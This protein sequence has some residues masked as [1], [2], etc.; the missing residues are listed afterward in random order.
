MAARQCRHN[1]AD[2]GPSE[3][4]TCVTS[5][6]PVAIRHGGRVCKE[7]AMMNAQRWQRLQE[8]FAQGCALPLSQQAAFAAQACTDDEP[9][10][11]ELARL[12]ALDVA[13]RSGGDAGDIAAQALAHAAAQWTG[14]TRQSLVGQ[15]LGPWQVVAHHADG[16]MGAVYR[17]ERADGSYEQAVAIK[18][19]NPAMLSAGGRQR[20]LQE[21]QILAR[22]AH[23][24]IARLLDG[25]ETADGMPYLVME[26][27]DG[28]P[29]DAWCR[30]RRSSVAERLQLMI[31]VCHAVDH[32]H[33]NLVVHRDL[34][35]G[36]I[37]VDALGEPRLLDF[38]IA[39]LVDVPGGVTASAARPLTP[40]HASPEQVSGAPITTAT[41]VYALGVL[42]YDLLTGRLPH[43]ESTDNPAALARAIVET[44]PP[45]PSRAVTSTASGTS[46]EQ[47]TQR[48]GERLT[49]QRLARELEGDLDNIVLM[50]LR[51]Q[52]ERRYASAA[53]LADD[54]ARHMAHLPVRAQ[55]DTLAYRA[56]KF[57][58]RHPVAVPSSALSL[59]AALAA[60]LLFTWRLAEERDRALVAE[61]RTAKAA[62]F[63]GS[64]LQQTGA[65]D[66]AER[67]VSVPQLLQRA[68]RKLDEDLRQEPEVAVRVRLGLGA[69][70]HSWGELDDA[71]KV[72][73]Q[74]V[75]T[76]RTMPDGEHEL[77]KGLETLSTVQHD[78]GELGAA[79]QL[80]RDADAIWR[81]IGTPWEQAQSLG[82]IAMGLNSLRRRDEAEPV[83]RD[84]IE[85]MRAVHPDGHLEIAWLLN[86]LAWGLHAM[87]RL[88]EA[89]PV[90][91][92]AV[93]MQQRL[94]A[95]RV[96][97]AQT[98]NNLAGLYYDRG[99]LGAAQRIWHEA[100]AT[101]E[102]VFGAEGHAAVA[103]GRNLLA[104][105]ALDRGRVDE[106]LRLSRQ[107]RDMLLRLQ[108]EQHRWTAAAIRGHGAALLAAGH[109]DEAEQAFA[110]AL[111]VQQAVLPAGHADQIGSH[112]NLGLVALRRG[113]AAQWRRAE[114]SLRTAWSLIE[115]IRSPDRLPVDRVLGRLAEALARQGR[116]E[117]ATAWLLRL[118]AWQRE[119]RPPGH[120][121]R[122]AWAVLQTLPPFQPR[123]SAEARDRAQV[124]LE[125]LRV[126]LG[127]QAPTVREIERALAS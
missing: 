117:E 107:A 11:H 96:E 35:P 68:A 85:R 103:R 50:A 24:H 63:V 66:D 42:L 33:R 75:S 30:A 53:A 98:L 116:H 26:F 57:V 32:A 110:R 69:A 56:R 84:A 49:Q 81:R 111:T 112:L 114:Q 113:G 55:P 21:R 12:L 94:Q 51:K 22:L 1:G 48:R 65:S 16:G 125:R 29:I 118:Q 47:A 54:L 52:P 46:R 79:L 91:E 34:K 126:D 25:G 38:G 5:A 76:A 8:L 78:R 124:E 10:A 90:Y 86:N 31:K 36:N 72:L 19:I 28:L 59:L 41:D 61:A 88:D 74:A 20:L 104:M 87:G 122:R 43:A 6:T 106:A 58:R 17:G 80:S 83:F 123:V 127:P 97:L 108:G 40:S 119:N 67:K 3:P 37:L 109:L 13:G 60:A 95:P 93:A 99:D 15:R 89:A 9:M 44:E 23:P 71:L 77:A 7:V 45:R 115:G 18:L 27:V 62:A 101:F 100:L 4:A 102:D 73:Q 105:V 121:R 64:L 70:L 39:K 14:G 92:Q 82:A 2:G 120:W